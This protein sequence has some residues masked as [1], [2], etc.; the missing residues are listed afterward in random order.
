VR[1]VHT[2]SEHVAW[3]YAIIAGAPLLVLTGGLVGVFLRRR[4]RGE[5]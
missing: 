4:S 3:F 5:V 2:R 1:I